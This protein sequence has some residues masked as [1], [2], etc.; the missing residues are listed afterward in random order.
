V[1]RRGSHAG[2]YRGHLIDRPN[3]GTALD[4]EAVTDLCTDLGSAPKN[5]LEFLQRGMQIG[6][7][8]ADSVIDQDG[9]DYLA[10]RD[11][12]YQVGRSVLAR[13]SNLDDM[14]DGERREYFRDA[15]GLLASMTA[16]LDRV[17]VDTTIQ[18]RFP[19]GEAARTNENVRDD[20]VSFLANTAPKQSRYGAH[21]G[22]RQVVESR[23]DKLKYR[24]PMDIDPT[25]RTADLTASWVVIGDGMDGL[26]D[27]VVAA[28]DD[29]EPRDAIQDGDEEGIA[30]DVPVHVGGT[31]AHAKAVVEDLISKKGWNT[32]RQDT[33]RV[34]RALMGVLSHAPG[35]VSPTI[36]ADALLGMG[37]ERV[38]AGPPD[39]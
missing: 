14:A 10:I 24:L 34:T 36:V 20:V 35:R 38:R 21:S 16:L 13:L 9:L 7:L 4:R 28:L 39:G 27:D 5:V 18:L 33:D 17:G 8:D 32:I 15:H 30:I 19:D 22:W 11:H 2:A 12:L 3:L 31:Y 26:R 29:V 37:N 23:P 25:A 1:G 6:W